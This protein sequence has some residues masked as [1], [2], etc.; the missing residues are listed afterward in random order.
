MIVKLENL[1]GVAHVDRDFFSTT[2]HVWA[3]LPLS[4]DAPHYNEQAYDFQQR[5]AKL[6]FDDGYQRVTIH[7]V[8]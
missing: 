2:L 6:A 8:A 5:V 7:A 1:P 4:R 3:K